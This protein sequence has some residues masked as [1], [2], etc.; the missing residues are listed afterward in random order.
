M[1]RLAGETAFMRLMQEP[2]AVRPGS[3]GVS[4]QPLAD[5]DCPAA[6]R[7]QANGYECER[8]EPAQ[9]PQLRAFFEHILRFY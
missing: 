1:V 5:S 8:Q 3:V 6:R 9:R 7:D 2:D 4:L